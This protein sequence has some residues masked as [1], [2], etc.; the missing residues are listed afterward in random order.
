MDTFYDQEV[1]TAFDEA[2][3]NAVDMDEP[4]YNWEDDLSNEAPINGTDVFEMDDVQSSI[5][6]ISSIFDEDHSD[7]LFESI[8]ADHLDD[9]EDESVDYEDLSGDIAYD[10]EDDLAL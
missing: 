5:D 8:D 3:A 1:D 10:D 2:V 6:R 7:E 9:F 4:D